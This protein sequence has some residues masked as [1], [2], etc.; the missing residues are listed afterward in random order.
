MLKGIR[1]GARLFAVDP[2]RTSSAQFA[3][4]WLGLHVGSDI[5][6]A[7]AVAREREEL[8]VQQVSH[9]R[10]LARLCHY[11]REG[12]PPPVCPVPGDCPKKSKV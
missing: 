1:N 7:N 8:A 6:L 11:C 9:Q 10:E 12:Q 2:R 3:E 4:E 5:A